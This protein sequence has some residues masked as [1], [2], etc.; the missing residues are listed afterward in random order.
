MK[1][2]IQA[3]LLIVLASLCLNL[4]S[5]TP[6]EVA[7]NIKEQADK[8]PATVI[9]YDHSLLNDNEKQVVAKLIDASR[10]IDEIFWR[11]V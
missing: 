3:I 1:K 7:P 6:R 4:T 2:Y 11:M 10:D 9:D 8:L 5:P